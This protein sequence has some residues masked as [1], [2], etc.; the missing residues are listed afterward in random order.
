AII[1]R[2]N[3]HARNMAY[4][5]FSAGAGGA[6]PARRGTPCGLVVDALDLPDD[7]RPGLLDDRRR[8]RERAAGPGARGPADGPGGGHRDRE[9]VA[10]RRRAGERDR[11]RGG[12]KA[13]VFAVVA[14]LGAG[15]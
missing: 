5:R 8:V 9:R 6:K 7:D 13:A 4:V 12:L 14:D 11:A 1:W 3:P 15:I 2:T 10:G